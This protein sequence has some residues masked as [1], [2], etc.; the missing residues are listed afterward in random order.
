MSNAIVWFRQDLRCTDNPALSAACDHNT[1]VIPLYILDEKAEALGKAQNWWLHYSLI[2]L[3]SELEK[4]GLHFCLRRGNPLDQ[5]TKLV[6]ENQI[7]VVYWNRC[8][9]PSAIKL[10][11][12]IKKSLEECDVKVITT[13]GSLLNE[14]WEIKNKSGHYFKVYTPFWRTCLKQLSIPS[15]TIIIKNP[16]SPQIYSEKLNDWNLLPKK[17]NWAKAF[18]HYWQPGEKGAQTKLDEFIKNNLQSYKVNRNVPAKNATSKLSPHL[19]FG[20]ISTWQVWRAIEEAK[21]DINCNLM[22]A[23]NFLSSLGWREFCYHLLYHFPDLADTNFKAKFDAFPWS[24]DDDLLKSWQQ[25]NTGYPIVDAGMREL[26]HTGFMHNRVRM[27][28]ASFLTKDL[29]IDWRSGTS[30][31]WDT[32][33]DADLANNAFNWQW[34]AGSGADAA[35]Y[36]RIFNPVLQGEKF[37]PKGDYVRQW[38]PELTKVLN[39]WIHKPWMAK[40]D[41]LG[42]RLG[43]DYPK[44]IVDHDEKRRIALLNYRMINQGLLK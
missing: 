20:E 22:A 13:N 34:V 3:E 17:P 39:K 18:S 16:T 10:E 11:L 19:H 41:E 28:V 30:W 43:V 1:I 21:L 6:S 44:P 9:E 35:P 31:F 4:I 36:F 7:D 25:G 15:P 24:Y 2:S 40:A 29:L 32:L 14:P 37:D 27:I 38:V 5:L 26:W 8:Y 42:V 33:M 12:L 23:E